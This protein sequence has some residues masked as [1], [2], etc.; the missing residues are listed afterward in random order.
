M[1]KENHS[2]NKASGNELIKKPV[3]DPLSTRA[4]GAYI[5]PAKLKMMQEQ[6]TDKSSQAFQRLAWEALKKVNQ[7]SC[8][9]N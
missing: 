3:L 2:L 8:E 9:Q 7:W 4:G 5:P 1:V 6:I